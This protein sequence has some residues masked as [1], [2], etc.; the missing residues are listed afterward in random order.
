VDATDDNDED[1]A[2]EVDEEAE[3][4]RE[5]VVRRRRDGLS[6]LPL[7]LPPE[8]PCRRWRSRP[9]LEAAEGAS[10]RLRDRRPCI[11]RLLLP[12]LL[13]GDAV[14]R[15]ASRDRGGRRA[16][17][18]PAAA[19]GDGDGDDVGIPARTTATR[20]RANMDTSSAGSWWPLAGVGAAPTAAAVGG[21]ASSHASLGR[22]GAAGAGTGGKPTEVAA[23][24][25]TGT[26][27]GPGEMA[28]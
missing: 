22:C 5:D 1:D 15:A 4:E 16:S 11:S 12:R 18:E 10:A 9:Y 27:T 20:T 8:R 26:R 28:G 23:P 21:L 13:A 14:G 19:P 24:A 17:P 25:S 2:V 6:S 3:E 7:L